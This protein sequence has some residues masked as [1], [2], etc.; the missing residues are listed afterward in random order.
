MTKARRPTKITFRFAADISIA[1]MKIIC[2]HRLRTA[3]KPT[4]LAAGKM[5]SISGNGALALAAL[6]AEHSTLPAK[7]KAILADFLAGKSDV[8]FPA[9]RKDH[10]RR[11]QHH[12]PGERCRSDR[13]FLRSRLRQEEA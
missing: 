9:G 12:L 5:Q 6:V 2:A 8:H 10:G 1:A 7:E 3:R 4:A 11:R 13:P